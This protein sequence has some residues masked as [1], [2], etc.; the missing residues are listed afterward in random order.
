[1][2][3]L[4]LSLITNIVPVVSVAVL[5]KVKMREARRCPCADPRIGRLGEEN[6]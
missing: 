1:V 4:M 5:I 2:S 3:E 6:D